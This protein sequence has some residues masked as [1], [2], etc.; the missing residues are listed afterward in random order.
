MRRIPRVPRR[1]FGLVVR[2]GG[3]SEKER[4]EEEE[5]ANSLSP[6]SERKGKKSQRD[7]REKGKTGERANRRDRQREREGRRK[8]HREEK[9]GGGVCRR[10]KKRRK[11]REEENENGRP[12]PRADPSVRIVLSVEANDAKTGVHCPRLRG[13]TTKACAATEK[14]ARP[15]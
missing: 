4:S 14:R 13:E 7:E 12:G 11:K 1:I 15:R 2:E 5:R 3:L 9:G 8:R 6:L 10:E